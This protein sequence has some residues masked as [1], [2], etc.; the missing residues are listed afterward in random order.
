M[1]LVSG[2]SDQ[3]QMSPQDSTYSL[4]YLETREATLEEMFTEWE[5][6]GGSEKAQEI[7]ESYQKAKAARLEVERIMPEI[8]KTPDYYR[9]QCE[10]LE[11]IILLVELSMEKQPAE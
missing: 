1:G 8:T 10:Y 4:D 3:A 7:R 6:S 2:C 9:H 5:S 11:A